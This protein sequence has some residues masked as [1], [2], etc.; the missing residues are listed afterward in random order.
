MEVVPML[1]TDKEWL[2]SAEASAFLGVH[3]TT[4]RRW[5]DAGQLPCFRTPGGHRRFR[6]TDLAGWMESRQM[7]PLASGAEDLV[8]D[9]I[10][11]ARREIVERRVGQESWY[12]AFDR[13]DD[14]QAMREAGQRLFGLAIQYAGRVTH[15]EPVVQEGCR[16]GGYYGQKCATYGVSLVDTM[17]AFFFFR[18]SL[19]RATRPGLA[20]RGQYDTEDVRMHR[21]LCYFLDQTMYACLA[22][23]EAAGRRDS[24]AIAA[25]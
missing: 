6:A 19:M 11:S 3:P 18:E 22:S 15:Y 2:S 14:R 4:L 9:A 16:I 24:P 5:S 21:Q 23:Y 13:D 1:Q 10:G 7:T 17:R 12:E 8:Q 25:I 20:T